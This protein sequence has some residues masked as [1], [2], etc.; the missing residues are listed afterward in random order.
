MITKEDLNNFAIPL[1]DKGYN[2][3]F[4][5]LPIHNANTYWDR[6]QLNFTIKRKSTNRDFYFS[7]D[8]YSEILEDIEELNDRISE[9]YRLINIIF[10]FG[11]YVVPSIDTQT[12]PNDWK[13]SLP[14]GNA[15]YDKISGMNLNMRQNERNFIKKDW[16]II[17]EIK[18]TYKCLKY[19][20]DQA[21]NN[22]KNL[23]RQIDDEETR[24]KMRDVFKDE[25]TF[26]R[27]KR[28]NDL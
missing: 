18:F 9:E 24:S 12:F 20:K 25:I 28:F 19:E 4:S 2:V 22:L 21:V 1:N 10:E 6:E 13:T 23:Y 3:Y 16:K 7:V 8:E 26:E 17:S 5:P 27:I 14:N 11:H 15:L